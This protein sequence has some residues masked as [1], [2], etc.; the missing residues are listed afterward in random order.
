MKKYKTAGG[1]RWSL[2]AKITEIE[3]EKESEHSV[4]INGRAHRKFSE[5]YAYHDTWEKAREFLL[6]HA[7]R[8]L[9]NAERAYH[10]ADV[11][12]SEILDLRK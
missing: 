8:N 4:W 10:R 9:E 1:H 5:Y 12:L 6:I 7:R 3:V 11:V 2:E